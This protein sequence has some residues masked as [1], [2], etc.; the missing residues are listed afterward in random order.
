MIL[1]D[2]GWQHPA[3]E[4]NN[5]WHGV[6][7][8]CSEPSRTFSGHGSGRTM[9]MFLVCVP[10]FPALVFARNLPS[11]PPRSGAASQP[12]ALKGA[13]LI[14]HQYGMCVVCFETLCTFVLKVV[15]LQEPRPCPQEPGPPALNAT[16]CARPN[17]DDSCGPRMATPRPRGQ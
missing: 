2:Q 12:W 14:T 5:C 9:E 16:T 3:P 6:L 10:D 1:V 11:E 8:H 7:R 13:A 17:M 4:V 15:T